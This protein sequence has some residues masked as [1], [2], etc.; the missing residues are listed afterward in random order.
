VCNLI[1]CHTRGRISENGKNLFI[2]AGCLFS[3]WFPTQHSFLFQLL[4]QVSYVLE[5]EKWLNILQDPTR[6]FNADKTSFQ[7]LSKAGK[8]LV[9]KGTE[10]CMKLVEA[11]QK[12]P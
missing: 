8:V 4:Q 9:T 2:F 11:W 1:E 7:F 5:D 12:R 6:I 3:R 10:I